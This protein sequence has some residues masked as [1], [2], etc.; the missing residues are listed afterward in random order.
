MRCRGPPGLASLRRSIQPTSIVEILRS[1]PGITPTAVIIWVSSTSDSPDATVALLEP[2]RVPR[3]LVVQHVARGL[4]EV[5]ALGGGVGRD[6]DA[7][8]ILAKRRWLFER[9]RLDPAGLTRS[10]P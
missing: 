7:D 9:G 8:R 4:L 10:D 5:Q 6:Q 3:D 1:V 2:R